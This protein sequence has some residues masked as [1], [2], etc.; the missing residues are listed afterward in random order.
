[1][2]VDDVMLQNYNSI[3]H[4]KNELSVV[5]SNN[6]IEKSTPIYTSYESFNKNFSKIDNSYYRA[7]KESAYICVHELYKKIKGLS[8]PEGYI[9]C[10]WIP[11]IFRKIVAH[12][13]WI[14]YGVTVD[15]MGDIKTVIFPLHM[16]PEISLMQ[17]SP[18]FNNSFEII[19]WVSKNLPADVVLV[20]K[21]NPWSFGI[22]SSSYYDRLRKIGN[23][24]LAS[25]DT[26]T[27]EWIERSLFTV[28]ITGTSGIESI[29]YNKPVLSFGRYQIINELPTVRYVS[30]FL[31]TKNAIKDLYNLSLQ[32]NDFI[33]SKVALHRAIMHSSFSLPNFSNY[34][35]S[36]FLVDELG[37]VLSSEL[38]KRYINDLS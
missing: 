9:F 2:F 6:G 20:I 23:V 7:F 28:A 26:N 33:K 22:R 31:D 38:Q 34:K 5:R 12:K 36:D 25:P 21:E 17:V 32:K 1:M 3:G 10:G 35:K 14:K 18:E 24:V 30:S 16:E 27:K 37:K 8:N 29:Y 19:T 11:T 13:Y 15:S 4:I